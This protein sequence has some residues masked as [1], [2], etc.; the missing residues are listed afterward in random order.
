MQTS[1]HEQELNNA[2]ARLK[3]GIQPQRDLWRGI[4]LSIESSQLNTTVQ[5]LNKRVWV[6]SAASFVFV[7]LM[8]WFVVKPDIN[9]RMDSV[10]NRYSNEENADVVEVLSLQH[11]KQL[12]TLLVDYEGQIAT[13]DNW[14]QQL[15]ELDRAALVIKAA[16]KEEPSN[17]AL[18]Q[19]LKNVYQQQINLVEVVHTSKWQQI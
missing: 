17:N 6:A 5:P 1:K 9:Q 16:L 19:M 2:L 4:E 14:Q 15:R 8:G 11:Q 10:N 7:L 3:K 12:T 13:T 18:L